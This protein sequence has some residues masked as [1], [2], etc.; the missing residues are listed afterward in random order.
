VAAGS[1]GDASARLRKLDGAAEVH[2]KAGPGPCTQRQGAATKPVRTSSAANLAP[3]APA[4]NEAA[5]LY[6]A[7]SGI[8]AAVGS[9]QRGQRPGFLV[10]V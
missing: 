1:G 6:S 7:R 5:S 9:P 2:A 4:L 8:F 3:P 10:R